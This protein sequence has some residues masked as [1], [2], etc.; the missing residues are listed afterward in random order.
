MNRPDTSL[1]RWQWYFP[2]G[3]TS[4]LQNPVPQQYIT[5]GTFQM[6]TYAFNSSGCADSVTKTLY[7]NPLPTATLPATQ[8]KQVGVPIK[9]PVTYSSGVRS[10][11]WEPAA[12]LD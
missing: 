8:T 12:T 2:N 6:K 11:S 1:V 9:I 4:Q 5:A 7:V 3:N 10:Y